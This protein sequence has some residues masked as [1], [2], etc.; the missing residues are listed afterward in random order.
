MG[1]LP[2]GTA[3]LAFRGTESAQ[4]GLQDVKILRK[5]VDYMQEVFP[6][7]QA[8][9]GNQKVYSAGV[10]K[11]DLR[12]GHMQNQVPSVQA[13]TGKR[14]V[15]VAFGF[16]GEFGVLEACWQQVTQGEQFRRREGSVL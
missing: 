15:G 6:G 5:N 13:H 16:S 7:V 8:H 3:I 10:D 11:A 12:R 2:G 4:D 9:T 1:W 14:P